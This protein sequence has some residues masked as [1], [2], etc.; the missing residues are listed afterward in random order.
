M[1]EKFRKQLEENGADVDTTLKR[2]MGNEAMYMKFLMRFPDDRNY[3]CIIENV[4]NCDYDAVFNGAHTLKG[5]SANLGLNPVYNASSQITG[6]LRGRMEHPVDVVKLNEYTG[7][8]K[9][10]YGCFRKILDN[11]K[12]AEMN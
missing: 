11:Y 3:D 4:K 8:L 12:S 7:Q 6:L 10:A 9:A 2:F 1:D 5:V